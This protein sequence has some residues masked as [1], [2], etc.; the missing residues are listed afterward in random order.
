MHHTIPIHRLDTI[1]VLSLSIPLATRLGPPTGRYTGQFE[2]PKFWIEGWWHIGF[3]KGLR[4]LY[5]YVFDA[6]SLTVTANDEQKLFACFPR[7]ILKKLI[8]L[9]ISVSWTLD[10]EEST[11]T[12]LPFMI[13]RGVKGK[14]LTMQF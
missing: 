8:T 7:D 6:D 10:D 9:E 12:K 11:R 2:V 14:I 1:R 13:K 4:K 3:M 5:V